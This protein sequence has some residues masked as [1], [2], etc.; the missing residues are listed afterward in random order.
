MKSTLHRTKSFAALALVGSIVLSGCTQTDNNVQSKEVK[1]VENKNKPNVLLIMADDMGFSDLGAF[2][3]EISTPNI[4]KIVAEGMQFTNFHVAGTCA[5]TRSMLMS[6]VDNH[7]NGM[8]NMLEVMADNQFGKKGYES[9]ITDNVA[10]VGELLQDNG[11]NTYMA[12]KWHLGKVSKS[13]P[14]NKGFTRSVALMESGADNW[15]EKTYMPQYKRVHYYED[16]KEISLPKDFYSSKYYADKLM[17]YIDEGEKTDKPFFGYLSFQAVHYPHQAPKE[18]TEKYMSYYTKG[19]NALREERF[20]KMKE[21]G[22]IPEDVKLSDMPKLPNWNSLTDKEKKYEAKRMAVYAGMVEYMDMS[23]GRVIEHLKNIGEYN[24]TVIMFLSDNGT[25]M[26]E[27]EKMF[28]KWYDKNYSLD[29]DT[30]GEKGSYV[31]SGPGWA[32]ASMTP[33]SNYKGSASEGGMMSPLV[34]KYPGVTK[35]GSKTDAFGYITDIT[36]TIFDMASIAEPN[37]EYKG[38]KVEK[39]DGKSMVDVL[40]GSAKKIHQDNES[41]AYEL[42]GGRALFKGDYKLVKNIAPFGD[43]QW[44]L[45]KYKEDITESHDLKGTMPA[46]FQ[47]MMNEYDQY[48]KD[49][50]LVEVPEDYNPVLQIGKNAK[51]F[52]KERATHKESK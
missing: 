37:G 22:L 20:N 38:R 12:G 33:Y 15:E 46:K 29:Y 36:P 31:S 34:V 41:V 39:I 51:R 14:I 35:P 7:L 27:L 21:M 28:P 25:D 47:E 6:G 48:V 24:N 30:L 49:Y 11:Y 5:P 44:H 50:N 52:A 8:G 45:Y 3:S 9:R 23:I 19:W 26:V 42:A 2:G 4:D 32:A 13:Q 17:N 40:D 1:K 18:Y 16:G 43:N 10:T